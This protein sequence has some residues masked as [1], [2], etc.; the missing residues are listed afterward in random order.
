MKVFLIITSMVFFVLGA[1]L[2]MFLG[3]VAAISQSNI[4]YS[5]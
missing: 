2:L 3:I 4:F 5:N 1:V